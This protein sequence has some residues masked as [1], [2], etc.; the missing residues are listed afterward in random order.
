MSLVGNQI[1]RR[2]DGGGEP[3]G[4]GLVRGAA[5]GHIQVSSLKA[6]LVPYTALAI[7]RSVGDGLKWTEGQ[8]E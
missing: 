2:G 5:A 1:G 6:P 7:P 4:L 3:Q 8:Q